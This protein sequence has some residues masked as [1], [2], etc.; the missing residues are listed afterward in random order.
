MFGSQQQAPPPPPLPD[1]LP[2]AP[3]YAA[4]PKPGGS[5]GLGFGSTLMTSGQGVDSSITNTAKKS[6]LGQ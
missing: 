1:P 3:T 2:A 5:Q 4:A 6:L